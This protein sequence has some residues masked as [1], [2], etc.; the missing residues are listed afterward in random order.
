MN[1]D[2]I[3]SK[4]E[5]IENKYNEKTKNIE[6]KI[7]SMEN[8]SDRQ[9]YTILIAGYSATKYALKGTIKGVKA[10]RQ[11]EKFTEEFKK[12]FN[13]EVIEEDVDKTFEKLAEIRQK[14][15]PVNVARRPFNMINLIK[16]LIKKKDKTKSLD[17]PKELSENEFENKRNNFIEEVK[18]GEDIKENITKKAQEY[19]NRP[20][21]QVEEID[22]GKE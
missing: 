19:N 10:K 4:V 6:N 18:I 16:K 5:Q 21:E 13:E 22:Y 12:H 7:N 17:Q 2:K 3:E 14:Q 11:G 20:K 8:D 15:N 9:T 1:I